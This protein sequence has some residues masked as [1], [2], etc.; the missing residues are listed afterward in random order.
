MDNRYGSNK[1]PQRPQG[2]AAPGSDLSSLLN[3]DDP[4]KIVDPSLESDVDPYTDSAKA[5]PYAP[6]GAAAAAGGA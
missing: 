4:S 3:E 6:P 5:F 2:Q 1:R